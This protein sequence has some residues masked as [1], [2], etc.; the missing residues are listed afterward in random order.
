[1]QVDINTQR[2]LFEIIAERVGN[3]SQ[4][5]K[6]LQQLLHVENRSLRNR[7]RGDTYLS[8]PEAY[9]LARYYNI[10]FDDIARRLEGESDSNSCPEVKLL[11][12]RYL[13]LINWDL[14]E[15]KCY[16]EG[17]QKEFEKLRDKGEKA[18]MKIICSEIPLVY[19]MPFEELTY[20]KIY[21]YYFHFIKLDITFEEFLVKIKPLN[22]N[23]HFQVITKAY[24]QVASEEIW[25][26]HTFEKLL[27]Q[28]EECVMYGKFKDTDTLQLLLDQIDSL[29]DHI[30]AMILKGTKMYGGRVE[31]F[32][33]ESVL[34]ES[35]TLIETANA[36]STMLLKIFM[37]QVIRTTHPQFL[38]YAS[39]TFDTQ[40]RRSN[41]IGKSSSLIKSKLINILSAQVKQ[42][43][44]RL[45]KIR[46]T[47]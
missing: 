2:A 46:D 42:Y 34:R 45:L 44:N 14:R 43:R 1:M 35:F 9:R 20:F 37:I 39:K 21:T 4:L 25:D 11:D 6:E 24:M 27:R 32:Y 7:Q 26:R 19:L 5:T 36:P 47:Q 17:L 33:Y 13:P 18:R 8:F 30:R 31:L 3:S 22:L 12:M 38:K 15:L 28:L 16:M 10:S 23:A 29:V 41:L 40:L